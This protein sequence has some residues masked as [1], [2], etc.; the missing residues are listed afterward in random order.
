MDAGDKQHSLAIFLYIQAF[1]KHIPQK[2][3]MDISR[4]SMVKLTFLFAFFIIASDMCMKLE[5][6]GP[7]AHWNC[8]NDSQCQFTCPTC[9]CR[10]INTWC[11]CPTPP[12]TDN[13]HIQA[14][15]IE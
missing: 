10:C 2:N 1:D 4:N 12:F 5:A 11:Q 8:D 15:E 13:I 7:I 3:K 6:R 14:P 9:G